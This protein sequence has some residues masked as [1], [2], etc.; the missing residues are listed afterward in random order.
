MQM[1]WFW[2]TA[3]A[4]E[5]TEAAP[6][7]LTQTKL[8]AKAKA[9]PTGPTTPAAKG[10][11]LPL[12]INLLC[13]QLL[14]VLLLLLCTADAEPAAVMPRRLFAPEQ[15]PTTGTQATTALLH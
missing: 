2:C 14:T 13:S 11:A 3:L 10:A 9:A 15:Q 8:V 1:Q 6:T 7:K 4:P 12:S 5:P